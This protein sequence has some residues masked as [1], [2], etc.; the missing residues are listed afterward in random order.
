M[1]ITT[2]LA[3]ICYEV[4]FRLNL[5]H[6]HYQELELTTTG[7]KQELTLMSVNCYPFPMQCMGYKNNYILYTWM[8]SLLLH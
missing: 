2:F 4:E 1:S 7:L 3:C 5:K 6:A 8:I